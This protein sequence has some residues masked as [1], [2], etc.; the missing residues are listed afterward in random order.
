MLLPHPHPPFSFL[1]SPPPRS[2]IS[3]PLLVPFPTSSLAF[4]PRLQLCRPSSATSS[5]LEPVGPHQP[6]PSSAKPKPSTTSFGP[7]LAS[8]CTVPRTT[9]VLSMALV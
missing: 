8:A 2:G 3:L 7:T 5:C 6:R 9:A 1:P 4:P